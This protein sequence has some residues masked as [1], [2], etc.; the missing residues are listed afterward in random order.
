MLPGCVGYEPAPI[1]L[2]TLDRAWA[3]R[4]NN[5]PGEFNG[6]RRPGLDDGLSL[7]EAITIA[8]YGNPELR[9]LRLEA[10]VE[11]ATAENA[12][13]WDDPVLSFDLMRNV[14]TGTNPWV[15][16]VALGFTVPLSGRLDVERDQAWADHAAARF[17]V[18]VAEWELARALTRDWVAWSSTLRQAEAQGRYLGDLDVLIETANALVEQGELAPAEARLLEIEQ[19][20]RGIA[21]LRLEAEAARQAR[22]LIAMMGLRPDG[23]YALTPTM[24]VPDD[25]D[26]THAPSPQTHPRVLAALAEYEQAEQALRREVVK[27]HPDLTI[28]PAFEDD[29]GQSRI[30]LGLGL[31]LPIWNANRQG[32]AQAEAARDAAHAQVELA[33]QEAAAEIHEALIRRR[34]ADELR[35]VVA[36]DLLP[37]TRR[38]IE[39]ARRL[40]ELGEVEVLLLSRAVVAAAQTELML[41]EL[42]AEAS[43]AAM[44]YQHLSQPRWALQPEAQPETD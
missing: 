21:M 20:Q 6:P 23:G 8:L 13:R 38:Q 12:G 17:A 36:D 42:E 18:V 11:R 14:E 35:R 33:Y 15:Y 3:Q 41:I 34:S 25:G 9:R 32:I 7:D 24:A 4:I 10:G 5:I 29:E 37:L 31:P 2:E 27:Q 22:A 28:G 16:G 19:T 43:A 39:E 30:G 26:A 44:D 1:D 40:V